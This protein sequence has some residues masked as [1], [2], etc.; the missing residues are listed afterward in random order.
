M[1]VMLKILNEKVHLV[2]TRFN[3]FEA[4]GYPKLRKLLQSQSLDMPL[5]KIISQSLS[6]VF[7]SP[8]PTSISDDARFILMAAMYI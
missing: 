4:E 2:S 6:N 7:E 5:Y 1:K 8:N 3:D